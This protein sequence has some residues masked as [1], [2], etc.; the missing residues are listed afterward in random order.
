MKKLFNNIKQRFGSFVNF[1]RNKI[2]NA[3]NDVF[4]FNFVY[5]T[6]ACASFVLAIINGIIALGNVMYILLI[7]CFLCLIN[8]LFSLQFAKLRK[9]AKILFVIELCA[10]YIVFISMGDNSGFVPLWLSVIPV[11]LLLLYG[12]KYGSIISLILFIVTGIMLWSPD[13]A[14][15]LTC[16]YDSSFKIIY[17]LL[18]IVFF[19]VGLFFELVRLFTQE[20]MLDAK[21]KYEKLSYTDLMTGVGSNTAYLERIEK[22]NLEIENESAKFAVVF[23]DCNC[24]KQA[25]DIYGHRHGSQL[26]IEIAHRIQDI[27]KNDKCYRIGGDEFCVIVTSEDINRLDELM[28]E[29]NQKVSYDHIEFENAFMTLSCAGGYAIFKEDDNRYNVVFQ[30]ADQA[31]YKHKKLLKIKYNLNLR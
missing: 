1:I 26:I 17:P 30:R 22:L 14:M 12:I 7:F 27:F 5:V 2:L 31:M 10:L 15:L 23:C 21:D 6:V 4:Q 18:F 25:N 9:T 19:I 8:F 11:G 29:F 13:S 28:A 16:S 20:E 24:I 3:K